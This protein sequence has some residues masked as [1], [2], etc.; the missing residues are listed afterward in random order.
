LNDENENSNNGNGSSNVR[1]IAGFSVPRANEK[2]AAQVI[3]ES[4]AQQPSS[5]C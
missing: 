2:A 1:R 4:F 3:F 5:L